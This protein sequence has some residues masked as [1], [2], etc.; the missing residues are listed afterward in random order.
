MEIL[1]LVIVWRVLFSF[2]DACDKHPKTFWLT[3]LIPWMKP[4][5]KN[6]YNL[7]RAGQPINVKWWAWVLPFDGVHLIK[8][9]MVFTVLNIAYLG[10][11]VRLVW[12]S[13]IIGMLIILA[14]IHI[15]IFRQD[16]LK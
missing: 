2:H 16:K 8:D 11:D 3:K 6:R 14:L 7:D 1:L 5:W 15:F 12:W 9:L 10:I 13:Y 4:N